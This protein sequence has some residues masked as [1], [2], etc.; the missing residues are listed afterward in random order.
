MTL[1]QLEYFV[2]IAEL[3]S[4]TRASQALGI[5]QP[6]LSRQVR[7][8]EVELRQSLLHRNGRGVVLT[9]AGAKLLDHARGVLHQ[10]LRAEEAVRHYRRGVA[11][12]VTVG[13]PPSIA[14]ALNVAMIRAF[15]SAHP[16]AVLG[17]TEAPSV[18]LREWVDAGRLDACLAYDL[19]AS[20][21]LDIEPIATEDV[22]LISSRR[23]RGAV[24][25]SRGGTKSSI[26]LREI[27]RL[28]LI[29]SSRPHAMRHLLETAFA[30]AR[31]V[32]NV[33]M[34]A[35]GVVA[36]L[37]FVHAGL[38]HAVLPRSALHSV[39]YADALATRR[40]VRPALHSTLTIVTSSRRPTTSTQRAL[41]ALLHELVPSA[42]R[43]GT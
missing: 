28:P 18:Y 42:L 8:L 6:T 39:S 31:L 4:F 24:G 38:G 37:D 5:I 26:T 16:D 33:V 10:V 3:G 19:P 13:M 25:R 32:P 14:R 36:V 23:S 11:G 1:K 7:M 21:G 17:V 15:R 12:R 43:A 29:A 35:D 2:R 34:E 40:I 22:F 27:G 20:D 9:E 30:S 41:I